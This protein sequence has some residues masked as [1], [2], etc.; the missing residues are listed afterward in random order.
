MAWRNNRYGRTL[1]L[2]ALLSGVTAL[3]ACSTFTAPTQPPAHPAAVAPSATTAGGGGG[4]APR[5]G[6]GTGGTGS[7]GTSTGSGSG[8]GGSSSSAGTGA[9]TGGSTGSGGASGTG[10]KA[11]LPVPAPLQPFPG[12]RAYAR[13]G[14]WQPAGR[15][16]GGKPALYETL[17][18]PPGD[19]KRAGIAWMDTKLLSAR[20]YSGSMSP[21]GGPYKYTA[22]VKRTAASSL[23]AAFNGGF[24]MADAHGGYYT[25]GRLIKPLVRGSASLVIYADGS[26]TVGAWGSDV[27]MTPS[28]VAV[29]Q[30]LF[31]LVAGGKP[32]A[33]AATPRWRT[34]GGTC[35]CG[36]G[37]QG[38][39]YQW[40]SGLGVTADGALVYVVG[41]V[42]SPLMLADVLM[43]AGAVRGMQLDINPTWPV[44]A[45]FKPA[46]PDGLAAP[47]NG[48]GLVDT[49]RGAATFFDPTY[50]RDFVTMSAR[51]APGSR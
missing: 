12:V 51:P 42:L 25:E 4:V 2:V 16:V 19:S 29:R 44:F 49:S 22:P 34:W 43:R 48:S 17:I 5:T 27:T 6:T 33:L 10:G 50:A 32:T 30:N 38:S 8:S 28:V 31:P 7:S 23:V 24:K 14:V 18:V 11:V 39:E 46:A 15:L 21:G 20:L 37:Q 41:P 36:A 40:R 26:I 13:A 45:S 3:A 9:S 47:S 1:P 35:P